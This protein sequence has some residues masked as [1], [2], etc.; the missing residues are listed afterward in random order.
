MAAYQSRL[1]RDP[2]PGGD[3]LHALGGGNHHTDHLVP[4]IVRG[5]HEGVLTVD[6]GLVGPAY[7]RHRHLDQ[8]LAGLEVG[9]GLGDHLDDVGG[10]DQDTSAA[11]F[12]AHGISNVGPTLFVRPLGGGTGRLA[13]ADLIC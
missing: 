3:L 9:Y 7:P 1:D 10:T 4:G 6:A 13:G 8:H 2:V 11:L 12:F 5:F